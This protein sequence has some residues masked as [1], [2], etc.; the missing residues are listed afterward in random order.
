[1]C[2][3]TYVTTGN[4]Y[5]CTYIISLCVNTNTST[6]TNSRAVDRTELLISELYLLA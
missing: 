1:M 3:R 5:V 4:N 6:G 2:I